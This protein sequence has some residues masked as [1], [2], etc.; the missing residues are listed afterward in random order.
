MLRRDVLVGAAAAAAWSG[1]AEA[2]TPDLV[3]GAFLYGFAPF[4]V[5][6][7]RRAAAFGAQNALA[8]R[9]TLADHN[10]RG[11]T[12]P[13]N[14]TV[15]ASAYLDLAPGPFE[16]AVPDMGRR[17][18]SVAFMDL[19][20]DNFAILGTR[21]TKGRPGAYWLAGPNWRGRA[22]AT[23]KLIRAPTNIVWMLVRTL[24]DG[25]S[26]LAAADLAQHGVTL[27]RVSD[28]EPPSPAIAPPMDAGDPANF[29]A[30]VNAALVG[31]NGANARR[32]RRFARVGLRAGDADAFAKLDPALQAAWRDTAPKTLSTLKGGLA[33]VGRDANGWRIPS[34]RLGDFGADDALRAA[35]ALGGIGALPPEEAMYLSARADSTGAPLDGANAYVWRVPAGGVPANAFW[36]LTM[37]APGSDGRVFLVDNPLDRYSIGDRTPGFVVGGDGAFDIQFGAAAPANPSNWLPAPAG[38]FRVTLRAYL[39]KPALRSGAWTPAAIVRA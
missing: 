34:A 13:N 35:V 26:D 38:P 33:A 19:F 3:R 28:H 23:A 14:D 17:Y 39:P 8:Y 1:R 12:A 5:A 15:Y 11:I 7:L 22:P 6:R 27:R 18:Y 2:A 9:A 24:V 31:A 37:Y 4:E 32:A 20:T 29:L 30:V 16:I 10:A 25:P 21:A 36:S